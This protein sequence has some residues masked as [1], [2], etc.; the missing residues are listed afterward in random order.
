MRN[1][2]INY[3]ITITLISQFEGK[4]GNAKDGKIILEYWWNAFWGHNML[5]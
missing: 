2:E 5:N 1:C 4:T 3:I